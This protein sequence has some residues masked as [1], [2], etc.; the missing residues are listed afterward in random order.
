[1]VADLD[2]E[3]VLDRVPIAAVVECFFGV[4]VVLLAV[5]AF[6]AVA[7]PCPSAARGEAKAQ[8]SAR[9]LPAPIHLRIFAR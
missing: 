4:A 8:I 5:P 9:A 7:E 2:G 3:D 1:M 6:E